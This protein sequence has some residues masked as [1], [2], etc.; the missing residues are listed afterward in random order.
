MDWYIAVL[1]KYAVFKGRARRKEYWMFMLIN[2]AF[3]YIASMLDNGLGMINKDLARGVIGIL[4]SL[5]IFVPSAAVAVRRIH[6]IGKSGW[7]VFFCYF[8]LF[9]VIPVLNKVLPLF[10]PSWEAAGRSMASI[11][12]IITVALYLIALVVGILMFIMTLID[13]DHG[14]NRYGPDPKE[15]A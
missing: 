6:D 4:Y 9:V 5:A 1:K 10:I 15:H 3:I 11:R 8:P 12:I 13:G 7:W 14:T 2:T